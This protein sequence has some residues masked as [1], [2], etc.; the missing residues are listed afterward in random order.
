MLPLH[1]LL[2]ISSLVSPSLTSQ[3]YVEVVKLKNK[4]FKNQFAHVLGVVV[5][6]EGSIR[7]I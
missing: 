7:R 1:L 2:Y 3:W 4:K 6:V 5:S